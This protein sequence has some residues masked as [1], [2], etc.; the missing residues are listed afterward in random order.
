MASGF[1]TEHRHRPAPS[2]S[3]PTCPY[4]RFGAD[5]FDR[6]LN[7]PDVSQMQRHGLNTRGASLIGTAAPVR[8]EV[9][10]IIDRRGDPTEIHASPH[11]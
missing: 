10:T 9:R 1:R 11:S 3:R 5:H 8:I 2:A 4:R 6:S 7:R